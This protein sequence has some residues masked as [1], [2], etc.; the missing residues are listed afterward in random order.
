MKQI[1]SLPGEIRSIIFSYTLYLPNKKELVH[2][3]K[4]R[5]TRWEYDNL[6]FVKHP[7]YLNS[8]L[9][10]TNTQFILTKHDRTNLLKVIDS[11]L[12]LNNENI[13]NVS[14]LY[15][16]LSQNY[17]YN[18]RNTMKYYKDVKHSKMQLRKSLYYDWLAL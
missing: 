10:N 15:S 16:L 17:I 8:H 7:V 12:T 6:Q 13:S 11:L 4:E 1:F 2:E 18:A 3:F 5:K 14:Y 9:S